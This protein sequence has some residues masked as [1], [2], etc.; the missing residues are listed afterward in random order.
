MEW[1]NF[2]KEKIHKAA[3]NTVSTLKGPPTSSKFLE[4]GVLTPEEVSLYICFFRVHFILTNSLQSSFKKQEMHS[5]S[6]AQHGNGK[7]EMQL[8]ELIIYQKKNN[9]L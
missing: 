2:G 5:F 1:L 7:L 8:A 9:F 4:E 3:I 6:N